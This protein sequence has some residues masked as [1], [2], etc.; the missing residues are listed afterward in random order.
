[1]GFC[2]FGA[3]IDT[4]ADSLADVPRHHSGLSSLALD[5]PC[6]NTDTLRLLAPVIATRTSLK[7]LHLSPE[8]TL[9]CSDMLPI[10]LPT[11]RSLPS[12]KD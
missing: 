12:L 6:V 1:M 5:Y 10:L 11:F 8:Y 2:G 3:A 7:C 4:A 9:L